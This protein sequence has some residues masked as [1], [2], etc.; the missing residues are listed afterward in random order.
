M[1]TDVCVFSSEMQATASIERSKELEVCFHIHL[2]FSWSLVYS[3]S[4]F[5][6]NQIRQ[7]PMSS[8]D[9]RDLRQSISDTEHTLD[10]HRQIQQQNM[11]RVEELQVQHNR[12]S[13][14]IP[15]LHTECLFMTHT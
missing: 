10:K 1:C 2:I 7:Q 11:D 3:I 13:I 4:I 9:A 6:Q 15:I 8:K 5:S 14:P 12:Y